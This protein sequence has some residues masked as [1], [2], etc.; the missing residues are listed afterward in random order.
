MIKLKDKKMNKDALLEIGV[1]ELPSSYIEPALSQMKDFALK[2]LDSAG[3]KYAALDVFATPRKLVL[4]ISGL[5]ALSE[6]RQEEILGPSFKAAK[7]SGGNFTQAAKG[8]ASKH[9]IEPEKLKSK[10][11]DRGDYFFFA[12]E[13]KGEKT[14]KFLLSIFP[15]IIKSISFPKTMVWEE[16]G[17][18]FARPIRSILALYDSKVIRF[19]IADVKSSNWTLGLRALGN[20]KIVVKSPSEYFSKLKNKSVI[21]KQSERKDI[22]QKSI[23]AA[24]KEVGKI[25]PDEALLS[26]INYLVEYPTAILCQF[27]KKYLALPSEVLTLCMRKHQKCFAVNDKK[28]KFTN[29]FIGV[30]NGLSQ[31]QD[32]V[33]SG[34]EKVVAAR[35][36]DAEFFYLN[37]LKK[38]LRPNTEKL[39]GLT[40]HK[41][42]GSVY[43]KVERIDALS[44]FLNE[45]FAM[46]L[47]KEDL[48]NA[49]YLS[50]ADL[51]SEMVFEYPELQGIIGRIYAAQLNEKPEIALAIE[52]HYLPLSAGG[53]LP[54]SKIAALI[55]LAD[56]IDTLCANFSI[57]LEPTGSAD[58]Y[59]LRRAA[60]AFIRIAMEI[61]PKENLQALIEKAFEIL[62]EKVKSAPKSAQAPQKLMQFFW[63]RL[64][65]MFEAEGFAADETKAIINAARFAGFGNLA[66]L[67]LKLKALK[68]AKSKGDFAQIAALFKR[69][70]NIAAQ[71]K[72][73]NIESKDAV[74]ETL[75]SE[76][77]EHALFSAMTAAK[78]ET[79]VF[80]DGAQYDL[81]FEQVL[82]MKPSIDDFFEKVMVMAEDENI[83][84]NRISLLNNIK[85]IFEAF[86]DFEALQ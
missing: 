26:E 56:K 33:K 82:K 60:I 15:D 25:I 50:K 63:Q 71:A 52:E 23:D 34:Y 80:I 13:I 39:K 28:G 29:Y 7:D 20:P 66:S 42:I 55:S 69:I 58:P 17:F 65:S 77:A 48:K 67:R 79:A 37:D 51:V 76:D 8:F 44:A 19:G 12:R 18:A 59:G 61:F 35:L 31:Y 70:N 41:E 22:A 54:K 72:K 73:Q 3:L 81:V 14:E 78:K 32:I 4:F 5:A 16:S 62:P 9:G 1:E 74:N 10:T 43:E 46:A 40:F 49:V 86:A 57:G 2:A 21:V 27:D 83:K 45:S 6:T 84:K 30:R 47:D 85:S 11:T 36:A 75:L 53:T 64:E 68:T 38:T 24:V